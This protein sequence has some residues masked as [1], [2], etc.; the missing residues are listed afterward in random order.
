MRLENLT[1]IFTKHIP[2]NKKDIN[3]NEV[4][5]LLKNVN[6]YKDNFINYYKKNKNKTNTN[7]TRNKNKT[8]RTRNKNKTNRTRNKTI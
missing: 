6:N 5:L 1:K 8:N 7:R 2:N 4:Y 3:D